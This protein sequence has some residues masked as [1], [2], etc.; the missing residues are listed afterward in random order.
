LN[1]AG[2]TTAGSIFEESLEAI[3]RSGYHG[4]LATRAKSIVNRIH[5]TAKMDRPVYRQEASS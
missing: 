4:I 1:R 2:I 5:P 3:V